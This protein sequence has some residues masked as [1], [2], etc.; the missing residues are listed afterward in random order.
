V[1]VLK[2]MV[3]WSLAMVRNGDVWA[4]EWQAKRR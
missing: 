1:I 4:I 2:A 3:Q